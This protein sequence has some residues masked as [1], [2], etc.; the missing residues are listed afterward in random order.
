MLDR[1]R[2]S[3]LQQETVVAPVTSQHVMLKMRKRA[4]RILATTTGVGNTVDALSASHG[5][6]RRHGLD[7]YSIITGSRPKSRPGKYPSC[8]SIAV[9]LQD[10]G[11]TWFGWHDSGQR[12][13]D[14]RHGLNHCWSCRNHTSSGVQ[15]C[16]HVSTCAKARS[17]VF[18]PAAWLPK[19]IMI[20]VC[21]ADMTSQVPRLLLEHQI[22]HP[23][24]SQATFW[25]GQH[26]LCCSKLFP[27]RVAE[28]SP[29]LF[30]QLVMICALPLG[31]QLVIQDISLH[32]GRLISGD[33][34]NGS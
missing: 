11:V 7:H 34:A 27:C 4:T 17:G 12:D 28:Q 15:L 14:R 18:L 9:P 6:D 32:P 31:R 29:P 5:S 1:Q 13:S 23:P 25:S 19:R 26:L 16:V 2:G 22:M 8:C 30:L 24:D 21:A 20:P 3:Y 33:Y 10:S